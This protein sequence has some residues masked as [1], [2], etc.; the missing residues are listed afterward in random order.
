[1]SNELSPEGPELQPDVTGEFAVEEAASED[2]GHLMPS[3][4]ELPADKELVPAAY[5]S[6]RLSNGTPASPPQ[7]LGERIGASVFQSLTDVHLFGRNTD[8]DPW[9]EVGPQT[10]EPVQLMAA[11]ELFTAAGAPVAEDDLGM[12]DMV[13]GRIAKTLGRTKQP[14]AENPGAAAGRSGKL[15][16]LKGKFAD[17]YSLQVAGQ[18]DA[19][20]VI[21]CALCLGMKRLGPR[22]GWF[23]AVSDEP[24]FTVEG[25]PT[26]LKA[27]AKGPVSKVHFRFVPAKVAQPGKVLER[28]FTAAN[29]FIRRAGGKLLKGDGSA[30]RRPVAFGGRQEGHRPGPQAR[31]CRR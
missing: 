7:T 6:I 26:A 10:P 29:Y 31:K 24:T 23:G 8:S 14:G 12:F 3:I 13:A 18:L 22:F 17:T 28:M 5:Y 19:A 16:A 11:Q 20:K 21:D 25:E 9:L 30:P 1:M 4:R 2:A 15:A 27:G